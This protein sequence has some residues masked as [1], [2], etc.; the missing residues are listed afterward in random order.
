M[1][2][3]IYFIKKS[4]ANLKGILIKSNQSK[5]YLLY[6]FI[7]GTF[8]WKTH[9]WSCSFNIYMASSLLLENI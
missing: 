3:K 5:M 2:L 1:I 9:H 7:V 8:T 4:N 6:W